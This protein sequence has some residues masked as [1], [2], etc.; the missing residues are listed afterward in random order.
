ML[1]FIK[2]LRF[3]FCGRKKYPSQSRFYNHTLLSGPL[4]LKDLIGPTQSNLVIRALYLIGI[5]FCTTVPVIF[6]GDKKASTQ[7]S[8]GQKYQQI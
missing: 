8:N 6:F 7:S 4:G 1:I 5:D 2:N 3:S